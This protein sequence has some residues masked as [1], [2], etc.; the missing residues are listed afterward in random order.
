VSNPI[1]HSVNVN[2]LLNPVK[3]GEKPKTQGRLYIPPSAE[4]PTL[5][6][7]S[8]FDSGNLA[9]AIKK[10]QYDY[11]L[12]LQNDT[13]TQGYTKWFFFKVRHKH[14]PKLLNPK[15]NVPPN[16]QMFKLTILNN[17]KRDSL[18]NYGMRVLMAV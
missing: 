14:V 1:E 9:V 5:E 6:F 8:R 10:A 12:L 3:L 2:E 17:T 11:D 7:D 18:Y 16:E 15:L 13:N 4:E